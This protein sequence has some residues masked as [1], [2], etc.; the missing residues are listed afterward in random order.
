MLIMILI[1]FLMIYSI[2]DFIC[3]YIFPSFSFVDLGGRR[4]WRSHVIEL[5]RNTSTCRIVMS[6]NWAK[7][8]EAKDLR[9]TKGYA[10]N[11]SIEPVTRTSQSNRRLA[12][13]HEP[14]KRRSARACVLS[15]IMN[16]YDERHHKRR[17]KRL[18]HAAGP[19]IWK[20]RKVM[21]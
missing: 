7:R 17:V 2:F 8:H 3:F 5:C 12:P 16:W 13:S 6:F 15:A 18:R 4:V 20:P 19:T 1:L 11:R 14:H 21:G 9:E 10:S